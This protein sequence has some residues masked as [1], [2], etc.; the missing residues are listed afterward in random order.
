MNT[1]SA[2]IGHIAAFFTIIIWG[3]TFIATKVLLRVLTPVEILFYRF[4]LGYLVLWLVAPRNLK[5]NSRKQEFYFM[6][7]GLLGVTLYFLLENF[8]LTFTLAANV[9]VI[10]AIAPF[11]TALFDYFFLHGEKPGLRF[12]IGFVVAITGICL[13]SFRGDSTVQLNPAGDLLA[14]A[15]AV[16]WAGYST[17]TKKISTFGYGTIQTTRRIFFYGLLFM[18]PA[19]FVFGFHLDFSVFTE[20]KNLANILFLGFGAS[21]LCF[22]TWNLAVKLLGPVKTSVYIYMV[23]VITVVTSVIILHEHVTLP[24]ILGIVLTIAGL[25]LSESRL[26]LKRQKSLNKKE[27]LRG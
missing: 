7:A 17:F 23:P 3:T 4:F 12:F 25:F 11:F 18:I 8:A 10:I 21:A 16:V 13:I 15:A 22:V 9:G 26:S 24:A 2:S 5:L 14:I 6:A 20:F 27:E 19:L 1:K